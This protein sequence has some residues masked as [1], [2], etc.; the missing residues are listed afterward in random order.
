MTMQ[1]IA[2]VLRAT[3]PA[4]HDVDQQG[5]RGPRVGQGVG[6]EE[7]EAALRPPPTAR[8]QRRERNLDRTG[9][10]LG[11]GVDGAEVAVQQALRL[12]LPVD[13]VAADR[14]TMSHYLRRYQHDLPNTVFALRA[15][16]GY[17][18][19]E[20]N[21]LRAILSH[22]GAAAQ[23]LITALGTLPEREQLYSWRH[24]IRPGFTAEVFRALLPHAAEPWL[25]PLLDGVHDAGL[26]HVAGLLAAGDVTGAELWVGKAAPLHYEPALVEKV[27]ALADTRA[28]DQVAQETKQL[29]AERDVE[30]EA[31][32]QAAYN[33][34]K[35][36]KRKGARRSAAESEVR[37]DYAKRIEAS[38]ASKGTKAEAARGQLTTFLGAD[39]SPARQKAAELARGDVATAQLLVPLLS[40]TDAP[41]TREALA[42]QALGGGSLSEHL[43]VAADL[44]ALLGPDVARASAVLEHV[45]RHPGSQA[46]L[47]WLVK[48]AL[49]QPGAPEAVADLEMIG[50]YPV[51]A[52]GGLAT[53]LDAGLPSKKLGAI[54]GHLSSPI[55]SWLATQA[56]SESVEV[57]KQVSYFLNDCPKGAAALQDAFTSLTGDHVALMRALRSASGKPALIASVLVEAK[58]REATVSY[59]AVV[60]S[61]QSSTKPDQVG[62]KLANAHTAAEMLLTA[63]LKDGAALHCAVDTHYYGGDKHKGGS[64]Q[65]GIFTTGGLQVGG[66]VIEV[67]NH[68]RSNKVDTMTS[69]HLYVGGS[70]GPELMASSEIGKACVDA[71]FAANGRHRFKAER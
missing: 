48:R 43:R 29:E 10:Q 14:V 52:L 57:L 53:A 61:G 11:A 7:G 2:H 64:Q 31:Q 44:A 28:G 60:L 18:L 21:L 22:A 35:R 4:L 1:N 68:Y 16:H 23:P 45:M 8:E 66:Q 33:G 54:A 62:A 46:H 6:F 49:A 20:A 38:A 51:S 3:P 30:A 25:A 65:T 63:R 24:L 71:Y 40:P 12:G 70:K 36:A 55:G 13:A 69:L 50:G 37:E 56:A 26:L 58:A 41:A 47:G 42:R 19:A 34:E 5:A 17:D 39:A 15:A 67:H 27:D 59:F 32:G 9:A